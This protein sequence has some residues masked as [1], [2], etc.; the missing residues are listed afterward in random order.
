MSGPDDSPDRREPGDNASVAYTPA[1]EADLAT[2][3]PNQA[4]RFYFMR[5]GIEYRLTHAIDLQQVTPQQG[6]L[7]TE[8]HIA[9][10]PECVIWFT[11]ADAEGK[12]PQ[13]TL[14]SIRVRQ[15]S[16]EEEDDA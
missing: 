10:M 9:G 11:I 8:E 16:H 7:I 3:V 6:Y 5:D 15:P 1:F 12:S 2:L 13:Y 14:D 4:Q